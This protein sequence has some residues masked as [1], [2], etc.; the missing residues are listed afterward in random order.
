MLALITERQ[1]TSLYQLV[2][3]R[4]NF[5]AAMSKAE[6]TKKY[7]VE[8]AASV[9]N[10][11]GFAGTT[12]SDLT[13]ATGLTKGSIYGNFT[14]KE[15]VAVEAFQY[16]VAKMRTE[17]H[18]AAKVSKSP[19]EQLMGIIDYL[20]TYVLNP[21]VPGGCVLLNTAV[22]ADDNNPALKGHVAAE[23]KKTVDTMAK[24]LH[25][26]VAAGEI[27]QECEP[28][29]LAYNIFCAIEGAVMMSRVQ[30][31][32]KPMQEIS[33]FWKEYLYSLR[34]KKKRP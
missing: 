27:I 30:G 29:T 33:N 9:F 4:R 19:L 1:T 8:V 14:T 21:P 32:T 16:A 5:I 20:R 3:S 6:K 18:A 24:L 26:A 31:S 23:L 7:I 34:T 13:T 28:R 15:E 17:V 2:Y 11:K 10:K 25:K 12:M 22:E